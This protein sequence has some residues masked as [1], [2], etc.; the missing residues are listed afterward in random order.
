MAIDPQSDPQS[1]SAYIAP[2]QSLAYSVVGTKT[3]PRGKALLVTG[4][5][6]TMT[7]EVIRQWFLQSI[8]P[9]VGT[10][11]TIELEGSGLSDAFLQKALAFRVSLEPPEELE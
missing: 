2:T 8:A 9:L 4:I 7:T 6:V 1:F 11:A 5:P 10:E 3:P